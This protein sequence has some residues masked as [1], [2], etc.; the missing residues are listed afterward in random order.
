MNEIFWINGD[1]PPPLAVVL[2]PRGDD[3]LQDELLRMK[4]GGIQILVS[5]LEEEEA[6]SLGLAQEGSV[7]NQIGMQFVCFPIPDVHVPP[8]LDSFRKFAEGLASRLQA[9]VSVGVHCRGSVGRATVTAACT[10]IQMGWKPEIALQAIA[11]ARGLA[12]PDTQEQRDWI[13]NYK[14]LKKSIRPAIPAAEKDKAAL[15]TRK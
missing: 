15:Q 13:L 2:R 5:L 7:A 3:W 10:L 9:G 14:A 12:V 6:A 8:N 4:Q 1:P 11:A